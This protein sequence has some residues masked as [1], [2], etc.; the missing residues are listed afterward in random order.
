LALIHF[1][2]DIQPI[3][4]FSIEETCMII[5]QCL[6]SC[7]SKAL[8]TRKVLPRFWF[9]R[10]FLLEEESQHE[11]FLSSTRIMNAFAA[12]SLLQ[13][14]SLRE[15]CQQPFEEFQATTSGILSSKQIEVL[16]R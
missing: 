16:W 11:R 2:I 14:H 9:E 12:Q 3:M 6:D 5:R 10:P 7:A 15:L 8:Q 1:D 13:R 4:T